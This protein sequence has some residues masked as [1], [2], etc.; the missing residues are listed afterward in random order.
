MSISKKSSFYLYQDEVWRSDNGNL[1]FRKV[2]DPEKVL[3]YASL[4]PDQVDEFV[5]IK[6]N[7]ATYIKNAPQEKLYRIITDIPTVEFLNEESFQSISSNV[8][9]Y[10]QE[11]EEWER[12]SIV[13]DVKKFYLAS[14]MKRNNTIEEEIRKHDKSAAK[15]NADSIN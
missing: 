9:D 11:I 8:S 10:L 12:M 1:C 6:P 4:T 14:R 13:R 3:K 5:E 2:S 7:P 15:P